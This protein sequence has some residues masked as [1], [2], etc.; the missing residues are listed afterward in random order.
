MS[1]AGSSSIRRLKD[2]AVVVN[3]HE[4]APVGGRAP[5]GR[6]GRRLEWFAEVCQWLTS[7]GRRHPGLLPLAN[8]SLRVSRLLPA[9]SS[10]PDV[11]AARRALE[12]KLLTHPC[13][14]LGPGYPGC[15][16]G[17]RQMRPP[18]TP[19]SSSASA[20]SR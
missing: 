7:R 12:R 13:Y 4:L 5:G 20:N 19:E 9:V 11:A 8:L 14:Q 2:V 3:L 1:I 18:E 6:D 17:A 10:E 16:V 15:V